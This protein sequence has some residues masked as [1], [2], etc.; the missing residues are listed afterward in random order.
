MSIALVLSLLSIIAAL[1]AAYSW[2]KAGSLKVSPEQAD[3]MRE[4]HF[5]KHGRTGYAAWTLFDGSDMEFTLKMQ[6]I[7]NCRGAIAAGSAALFQGAST[8][9]TEILPTLC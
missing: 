7:W 4:A 9:V 6:S 1:I 8:F 3:E 5:A 2:F